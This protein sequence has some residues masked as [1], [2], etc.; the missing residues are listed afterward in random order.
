P[1]RHWK[2]GAHGNQVSKSILF[3]AIEKLLSADSELSY[4]PSY[5]L[6]IDDLRDYRYYKDDMLHP[7]PKAVEYIWEHFSDTYFTSETKRI[8]KEASKIIVATRHRVMGENSSELI[9]F[10]K[11]MISRIDRLSSSNPE[12]DMAMEKEYFRRLGNLK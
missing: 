8:Y 7:S 1:V 5:E 9:N 11:T 10:C 2:D 12:I 6:L 3:V 4:F